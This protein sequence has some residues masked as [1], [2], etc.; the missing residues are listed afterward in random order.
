VISKQNIYSNLRH[1]GMS[2]L[3]E[4][5]AMLVWGKLFFLVTVGHNDGDTLSYLLSD[6][7]VGVCSFKKLVTASF[8]ILSSF[9]PTHGNCQ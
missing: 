4:S 8:S 6:S 9:S 2:G 5:N 3:R 1:S 7:G